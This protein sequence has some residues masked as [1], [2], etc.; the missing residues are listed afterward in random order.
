M[1][2][3]SPRASDP[4]NHSREVDYELSSPPGATAPSWRARKNRRRHGRLYAHRIAASC[5]PRPHSFYQ[6][7]IACA[8]V[9]DDGGLRHQQDTGR[10]LRAPERFEANFFRERLLDMVARDL[11]L[12]PIEFR[13]KNLIK[14]AELPFAHRQARSL[15]ARDRS[16]PATITSL[17]T[18]VARIRLGENGLQGKLVDGRYHGLAACRSWRA[19]AGQGERAS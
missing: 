3:G 18:R 19:A 8:T 4:T 1:D 6:V 12:E 13:R 10:H 7:L 17:R 15:R 2:R 16:T 5:R 14:E 11:G 9:A